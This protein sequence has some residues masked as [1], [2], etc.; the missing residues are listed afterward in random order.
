MIDVKIK[1]DKLIAKIK[2]VERW[3]E[4][5]DG[6]KNTGRDNRQGRISLT[7]ICEICEGKNEEKKEPI[8]GMIQFYRG[9]NGKYLGVSNLVEKKK[10]PNNNGWGEWTFSI[11]CKEQIIFR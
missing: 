8:S 9:K 2:S 10:W 1:R 11:R 7:W 3:K 5:D 6:L 4:Y